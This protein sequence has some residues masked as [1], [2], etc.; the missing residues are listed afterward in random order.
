MAKSQIVWLGLEGG[1]VIGVFSSR[2]R[3]LQWCKPKEV[4][5]MVVDD[6]PE[7]D[8]SESEDSDEDE[9]ESEDSDDFDEEEPEEYDE[10]DDSDDE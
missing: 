1:E 3:A 9:E 4:Y 8:E 7:P 6:V 5:R 2:K 10:S